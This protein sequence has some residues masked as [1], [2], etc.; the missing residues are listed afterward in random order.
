MS[1]H[2][3]SHGH[4]DKTSHS[5]TSSS[6]PPSLPPLSEARDERAKGK[7]T[8]GTTHEEGEED[9]DYHDEEKGGEVE[10]VSKGEGTFIAVVLVMLKL[11]TIYHNIDDN[12]LSVRRGHE[13]GGA[14]R[15]RAG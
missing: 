10:D 13:V 3:A 4:L 14:A 1:T 11:M 12:S 9:E 2:L 5:A 15:E 6:L 8:D 7:A